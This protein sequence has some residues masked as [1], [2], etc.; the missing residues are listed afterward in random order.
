[1]EALRVD[2]AQGP[3]HRLGRCVSLERSAACDEAVSFFGHDE[4]NVYAKILADPHCACQLRWR[5]QKVPSWVPA[6][7]NGLDGCEAPTTEDVASL[8]AD[9]ESSESQFN[10]FV[11]ALDAASGC[12]HDAGGRK[13][14]AATVA[15]VRKAREAWTKVLSKPD[16]SPAEL[17]TANGP[18]CQLRIRLIKACNEDSS[19]CQSGCP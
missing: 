18:A 13:K 2:D 3:A 6:K 1:M 4:P 11:T 19:G 12:E 5:Y 15:A 16:P 7:T 17:A 14:M 10:R 9:L 8:K